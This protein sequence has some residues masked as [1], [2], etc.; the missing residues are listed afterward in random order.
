MRRWLFN[1][2]LVVSCLF[3]VYPIVNMAAQ[4]FDMELSSVFAGKGTIIIGGIP[5]NGGIFFPNTANL[6]DAFSLYAYPRVAANSVIIALSS[7]AMALAAG[8]P[9]AYFLARSKLKGKTALGFL[10][11]ALRTVS[12]FAI[13]VPLYLFYTRNGLWNNYLGVAVAYLVIDLPVVVWML[14]SFFV[15]V[16]KEVY[17]AAEVSGASERQIFWRVALPAIMYGIIATAIFAFVLIWNE[18]L[19]ADILTGGGTKTV[20]VS[21]WTGAGENILAF[22]TVDW[23][24]GNMLGTLAFIPAFAIILGIKKYLARGFSLAT[25]R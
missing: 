16:P 18:F 20:S 25:A 5:L 23:D 12:P 9:A 6:V 4:G 13:I 7:I 3:L 21:V 22:R 17:D 15:D 11:L 10:I 2:S 19:M 14:R 1:L 8:L 24:V